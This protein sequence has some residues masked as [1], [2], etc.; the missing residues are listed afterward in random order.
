M[1]YWYHL[2]GGVEDYPKAGPKELTTVDIMIHILCPSSPL[3]A[4]STWGVT[5]IFGLRDSKTVIAFRA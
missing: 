2:G 3:L 1:N 4:V 5:S